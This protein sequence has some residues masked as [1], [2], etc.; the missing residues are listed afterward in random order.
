MVLS[1]NSVIAP[2]G[3]IRPIWLTLPWV[4]H[5][6]P[7]GP[8]VMSRGPLLAVGGENS[9]T[10]PPGVTRTILPVPSFT[11]QAFPSP[12]TAIP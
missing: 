1:G 3:V 7:S 12:S 4:N 5:R 10:T 9:L 11:V 2:D 6:F 8:M